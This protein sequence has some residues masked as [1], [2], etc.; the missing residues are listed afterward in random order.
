MLCKDAGASMREADKEIAKSHVLKKHCPGNRREKGQVV[1]ERV[2]N[3]LR[4]VPGMFRPDHG[5]NGCTQKVLQFQAP[6]K[7]C[8]M[9]PTRAFSGRLA[10]AGASISIA[11]ALFS[12]L[13][14][15][16]RLERRCSH[17]RKEP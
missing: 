6:W 13:S 5:E 11:A 12:E 9:L 14:L 7:L 17:S 1:H 8:A 3:V 4:R 15:L 16:V 2:K 10:G